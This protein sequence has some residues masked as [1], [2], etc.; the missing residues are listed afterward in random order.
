MIF[1]GGLGFWISARKSVFCY[2]TPD[3]VNGLFVAPGETVDL[4]HLDRFF[5]LFLP[6]NARFRKK[7]TG[8]RAKKSSPTP[9]WG[10]CLPVTALAL[11]ARG[12]ERRK[13]F[14]TRQDRNRVR[15]QKHPPLPNLMAVKPLTRYW[16]K[17]LLEKKWK[18][19]FS[20]LE[21]R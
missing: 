14:F 3:F 18:L 6:R 20:F 4:A 16:W 9:L 21:R 12:L 1:L 17:E 13:P 10:H 11:S 5:L 19:S 7:K 8:W 2:R 15:A